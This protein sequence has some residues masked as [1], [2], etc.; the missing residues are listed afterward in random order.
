MNLSDCSASLI[1]V[2]GLVARN[3]FREWV[4]EEKGAGLL[5]SFRNK[6]DDVRL[7]EMICLLMRCVGVNL[8][9][10]LKQ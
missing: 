2:E 1:L 7:K 6:R 8:E 3:P 4:G 5:L 10:Q 9:F